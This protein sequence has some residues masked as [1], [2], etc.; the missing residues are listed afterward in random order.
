METITQ[1]QIAARAYERFLERGRQHGHDVE[2]WLAAKEELQRRLRRYEVRLVDA[3]PRVIE[4]VRMIRELTQMELR[5]VKNV[6]DFAPATL[7]P[8]VSAAEAERLQE[9]LESLGARV[10]L[11]VLTS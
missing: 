8:D 9:Q 2:D 1:E 4:L 10:E 6:V 3:G 11:R 7:A 5:E